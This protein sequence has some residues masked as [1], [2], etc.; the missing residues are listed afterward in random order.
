MFSQAK[1]ETWP[2]DTGE[3]NINHVQPYCE[4]RCE[5]WVDSQ[6]CCNDCSE[7]Q[8]RSNAIDVVENDLSITQISRSLLCDLASEKHRVNAENRTQLTE[9]HRRIQ[10]AHTQ[11]RQTLSGDLRSPVPF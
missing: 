9:Q 3:L 8:I 1:H 11:A 6:F 4:P 2:C 5:V 10:N 7:M